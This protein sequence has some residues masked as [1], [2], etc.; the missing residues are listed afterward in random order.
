MKILIVAFAIALLYPLWANGKDPIDVPFLSEL[1][2]TEQ[3]YVIVE[4]ENYTVGDECNLLIALHGHGSD[5]W[6]FIRDS[7]SECRA[8]R[9]FATKLGFIYVSPD[10]RAKTSWMGPSAEADVLQILKILKNQYRIKRTILAGGSMG[11]TAA[12]SFAVLHPEMVDGVIAMNG[13]ANLEEYDQFQDAISQSFGG[14]KRQA[15]EEYRKRS[16][17][18]FPDRLRMPIAFTTGGL[19]RSVPPDSS[20]R[21]ATTLKNQGAPVLHIHQPEGGHSTNYEDATK[22]FSYVW[23]QLNR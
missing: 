21:L 15:P 3:R 11:G 1:D 6:Q 13:T 5:R 19:D 16:A 22:A 23:E 18:N 4:A 17:E 14:T 9:D 12:L 8:A 2:G 20:L 10:Y 7:R